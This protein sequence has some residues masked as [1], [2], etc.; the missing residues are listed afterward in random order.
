MS[1]KF[2]WTI[3]DILPMERVGAKQT[4]K[5]VVVV[6]E[7]KTKKT[8][9]QSKIGIVATF[10]SNRA[11]QIWIGM[12][13]IWEEVEITYGL[14]ATEYNGRRYQNIDGYGISRTN[15]VPEELAFKSDGDELF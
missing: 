13:K 6:H 1:L 2:I 15:I 9:E 8:W 7:N 12:Y 3:T 5:R 4:P 14:S 11:D 10:F